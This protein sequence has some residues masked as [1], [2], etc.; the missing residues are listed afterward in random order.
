[1]A[2]KWRYA[3]W[4]YAGKRI[5]AEQRNS[6]TDTKSRRNG[7]NTKTGSNHRACDHIWFKLEIKYL[8][9]LQLKDAMS[10]LTAYRI[11]DATQVNSIGSIYLYYLPGYDFLFA[12]VKETVPIIR[13]NCTQHT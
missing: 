6:P 2:S 12:T 8:G 7:T 3:N 1:M 5:T 4:V 11:C 9:Q 13:Q 10:V